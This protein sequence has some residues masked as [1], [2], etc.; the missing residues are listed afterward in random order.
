M[1]LNP[2]R[3]E[4]FR[5]GVGI[6]LSDGRGR[7]LA[8]ERSDRAGAWQMPQGGLDRGETIHAAALRELYEE[9]GLAGA[10]IAIVAEHPEWLCYELPPDRRNLKL[11]RGQVQ[12]WVLASYAGDPDA[13][14]LDAAPDDE[15][16]SFR[17]MP[18]EDLVEIVAA[19]RK[20]VY[21][22]LLAEFGPRLS[23]AR[24]PEP[25]SASAPS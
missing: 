12:K 16:Q 15:F 7:V 18:L 9:T 22:R 11:G 4:F 1:P 3:H 25:P 24:P 13:I 17:W 14:D 19:F 21:R 2:A 10:A 23:T 6:V 8:L 5:A 20:P